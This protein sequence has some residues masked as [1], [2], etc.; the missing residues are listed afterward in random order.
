MNATA[1][2]TEK[3]NICNETICGDRCTEEGNILVSFMCMT[4]ELRYL[5]VLVVV[6]LICSP[7]FWWIWSSFIKFLVKKPRVLHNTACNALAMVVP[8]FFRSE[9]VVGYAI[10]PRGNLFVAIYCLRWIHLYSENA[11]YG[12]PLHDEITS[13]F[14]QTNISILIILHLLSEHFK[15]IVEYHF[16]VSDFP[17]LSFIP[18]CTLQTSSLVDGDKLHR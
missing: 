11:W 6:V 4:E 1:I 18:F 2:P 12:S 7:G 9:W 5:F 16:C 17:I 13:T 3:E 14:C 15:L 10:D 8:E